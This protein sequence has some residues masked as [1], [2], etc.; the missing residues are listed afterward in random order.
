MVALVSS[1]VLAVV[2]GSVVTLVGLTVG[3]QLQGWQVLLG[4]SLM[5]SHSLG[6]LH[7]LP[8]RPR[9]HGRNLRPAVLAIAGLA[10]V[11]AIVRA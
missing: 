8:I 6:L 3:S 5:P 9:L 4:L 11:L 10:G 2:I 7:S 1:E